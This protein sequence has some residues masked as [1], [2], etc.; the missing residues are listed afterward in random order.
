[1]EFEFQ[2]VAKGEEMTDRETMSR[3]EADDTWRDHAGPTHARYLNIT[4]LCD[5]THLQSSQSLRST[6]AHSTRK[7]V[8][9][10]EVALKDTGISSSSPSPRTA[11]DERTVGQDAVEN[12]AW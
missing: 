7:L 12:D 10:N 8:S 1:M 2:I 6:T 4:F 5:V 9:L 3:L 11:I